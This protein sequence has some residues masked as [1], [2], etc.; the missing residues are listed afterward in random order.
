MFVVDR[1]FYGCPTRSIFVSNVTPQTP[2]ALA[3]ARHV[4]AP[5]RRML[6]PGPLAGR[7]PAVAAMVVLFLVPYLALSAALQPITPLVSGT[8]HISPQ[9]TS[10]ASG[11][12]N[13]AYAAGT[14]LAV[15]FAQH[16]PQRRMMLIYA[17]FLVIGS[18][19]AAAATDPLMFIVGHILQGLCTSL[20]LIAAAPPL[21]LGYPAA[22]LRWTT[23]IMNMCIFGAVAA[24]PLIGGAQASFHA[25]RP[26][27]WIAAGIAVLG[28]VLALLTFEDAPPADR[29]APRDGRAIALAAGGSV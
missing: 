14:V 3:S 12:A 2:P 24:G 5:A 17:A 9:A 11:M 1:T 6:R 16:L 15:Q 4:L 22:K 19:L 13:A 10:L 18:V 7:Y 26:L 29:S 27:F 23:M 8:L 28:L 20:L 21:F 25:W